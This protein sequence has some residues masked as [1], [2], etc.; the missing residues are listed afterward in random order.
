MDKAGLDTTYQVDFCIHGFEAFELLKQT[1]NCGMSYKLIL[2]DFNMPICNGI[3]A[4]KMIRE[5]LTNDS[6]IK[7][8]D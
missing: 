5:Y 2:T 7:K 8:E 3:K 1:Y 4:T 6:G